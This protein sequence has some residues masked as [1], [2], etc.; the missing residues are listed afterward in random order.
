[1]SSNI[2]CYSAYLGSH[3]HTEI[4]TYTVLLLELSK[5]CRITYQFKVYLSKHKMLLYICNI[6]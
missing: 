3:W 2:I 4:N 6:L 1:M 5:L